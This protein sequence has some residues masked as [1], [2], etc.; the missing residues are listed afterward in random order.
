[1]TNKIDEFLNILEDLL[2]RGAKVPLTGGRALVYA[3][4][5]LEVI[6]ELRAFLPDELK[7]ADDILT[8]EESIIESAK[9]S[10]DLISRKAEEKA[11]LVLN[12]TEITKR[13]QIKAQD[14]ISEATINARE[15]KNSTYQYLSDL[16]NKAEKGL[17]GCLNDIK[18]TKEVINQSSLA[19]PTE[20]KDKN[21]ERM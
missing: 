10:A 5:G 15:V 12:E 4:E 16:L 13:A 21:A 11:C 6:N 14:I 9:N 20:S 8:R 7:K 3:N 18:T 17:Q 2:S 19:R 1:M